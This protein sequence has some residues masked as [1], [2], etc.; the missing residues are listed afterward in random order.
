[1]VSGSVGMGAV[2]DQVNAVLPAEM[3]LVNSYLPTETPFSS[4]IAQIT[5]RAKTYYLFLYFIQKTIYH[6]KNTK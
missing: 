4:A 5:S 6:D 3:P 1:M 2:L